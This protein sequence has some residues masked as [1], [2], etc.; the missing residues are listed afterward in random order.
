MEVESQCHEAYH[1]DEEADEVDDDEETGALTEVNSPKVAVYEDWDSTLAYMTSVASEGGTRRGK[2]L[3]GD[4]DFKRGGSRIV[5]KCVNP[6]CKFRM[7]ARKQKGGYVIDAEWCE[8][9]HYTLSDDG[10]IGICIN[11]AKATVV[12]TVLCPS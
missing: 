7:M 11:R 4:K 10:M 2:L 1:V 3:S 8:T 6:D 5:K 12:R 9:R